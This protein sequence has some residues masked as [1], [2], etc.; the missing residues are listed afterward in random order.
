MTDKHFILHFYLNCTSHNP[1]RNNLNV[2]FLY[3]Q[4]LHSVAFNHSFILLNSIQLVFSS[5]QNPWIILMEIYMWMNYYTFIFLPLHLSRYVTFFFLSCCLRIQ[6]KKQTSHW[7]LCLFIIFQW[8]LL[9]YRRSNN[10]HAY[11]ARNFFCTRTI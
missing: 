11:T 7:M 2:S 8:I 10:F 9:P 3:F 1:N 6:K 4:K 5:L